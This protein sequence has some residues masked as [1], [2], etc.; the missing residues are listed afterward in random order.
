LGQPL[1][2]L[3]ASASSFIN[4]TDLRNWKLISNILSINSV[5]S[6]YTN[7]G[8]LETFSYQLLQKSYIWMTEGSTEWEISQNT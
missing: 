3:R 2:I 6:D 1:R 4:W 7:F 8:S 5:D